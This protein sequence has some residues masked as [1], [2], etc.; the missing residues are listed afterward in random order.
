[1]KGPILPWL[2]SIDGLNTHD[3]GYELAMAGGV[4]SVQVLPGSN[5]AIG[6]RFVDCVHGVGLTWQFL[7]ADKLFL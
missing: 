1:M 2:R 6:E 3:D 7:Q 5:N 4:T